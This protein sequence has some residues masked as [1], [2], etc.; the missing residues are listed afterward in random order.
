LNDKYF[1]E[2]T[3]QQK[4]HHEAR[5]C[6]DVFLSKRIKEEGRII[7]V[8]ADGIGHGIKANLL[9]TLAS[10][11]A[12]KFTE[13]H[14]SVEQLAGII[15][16]TLPVDSI[17]KTNYSTFTIIDIDTEGEVKILEYENPKTL[18]MRGSKF[19]EP[20]WNI[21]L[22][23]NEKSPGR[24]VLTTS[25]TA[26]KEDRIIFCSDG[27]VQSGLGTDRY[28]MGWGMENLSDLLTET[29]GDE[30]DISATRL[31][32]KLID[33]ANLNDGLM[34]KDDASS[35]VIY[36]RHPRKLMICTGPPLNESTDPEFAKILAD[37]D[38]KKIICGATTA[39]LISREW[40]R[41]V[42]DT[43]EFTD[44]DLPPISHM[45]GVEFVTEGILTL[46]KINEVLKKY[47]QDYKLGKGAADEVVKRILESD[48]IHFIAGTRVNEANQDPTLPIDLELRRTIVHRIVRVL[49]EKFLKETTM[50]FF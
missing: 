45:E 43:N 34:L 36:F 10:T 35:A 15:M 1:I 42:T 38:G 47:T 26:Q 2:V 12:L 44:P 25:F 27:V 32:A 7:A 37:F 3:C 50:R 24:E 9:A 13:E 48:E 46:S 29:V 17:K 8:L 23:D 16:E 30:P 6:G 39:D 28:A 21:I 31:A 33:K 11:L 22:L 5:V 14:K 41:P 4:P 20:K 19:F 40:K 49:E 18:I